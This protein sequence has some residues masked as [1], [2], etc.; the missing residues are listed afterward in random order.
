M[1]VE[2]PPPGPKLPDDW[3]QYLLIISQEIK[4]GNS[5]IEWQLFAD[6]W[7]T[8]ALIEGPATYSDVGGAK[9]QIHITVDEPENKD[10]SKIRFTLSDSFHPEIQHD[11]PWYVG[12]NGDMGQE[13]FGLNW[14]GVAEKGSDWHEDNGTWKRKVRCGFLNDL[15]NAMLPKSI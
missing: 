14:C 4:P 3:I 10:K 2:P 5:H 9:F 7:G 8:N 1:K 15:K 12:A 11:A 13:Y 6:P